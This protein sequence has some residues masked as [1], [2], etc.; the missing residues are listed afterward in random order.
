MGAGV[1]AGVG[2][3]VDADQAKSLAG[4]AF[5]DALWDKLSGGGASVSRAAWEQAREQA[6]RPER[7]WRHDNAPVGLQCVL[8]PRGRS[9]RKVDVF[10]EPPAF[11]AGAADGELVSVSA[12]DQHVFGRS[13][14]GHAITAMCLVAKHSL[15]YT[16]A[17]DGNIRKWN[18]LEHTE[19]GLND[20]H[21]YA[22]HSRCHR[23]AFAAPAAPAPLLA[24][25]LYQRLD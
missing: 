14:D 12:A 3:V 24:K 10:G 25:P 4:S 17:E 7:V 19:M 6:T 8:V 9:S 13:F 11:M 2:D 21:R 16:A 5:D 23:R 18:T 22:P 20:T 1:S 15:L